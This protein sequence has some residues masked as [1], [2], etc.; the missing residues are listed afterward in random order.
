MGEASPRSSFENG[1]TEAQ[2]GQELGW[3]QGKGGLNLS[4]WTPSLG[5]AQDTL[6]SSNG[7]ALQERGGHRHSCPV[8]G[9]AGVSWVWLCSPTGT[10]LIL[11]GEL[12]GAQ[13][14]LVVLGEPSR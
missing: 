8:L 4:L 6:L 2:R 1:E 11:E 10:R 9:G 3:A 13:A 14:C 12:L 5:P 7:G